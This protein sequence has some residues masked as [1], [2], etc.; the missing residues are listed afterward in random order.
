MQLVMLLLTS[1]NRCSALLLRTT[2]A[3]RP[4]S[5]LS[6]TGSTCSRILR[7]HLVVSQTVPRRHQSQTVP[8][9]RRCV[10]ITGRRKNT[11]LP[12][13]GYIDRSYLA[14]LSRININNAPAPADYLTLP[15]GDPRVKQLEAV[16]DRVVQAAGLEDFSW[17]VRLLVA[18]REC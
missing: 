11:S 7:P 10:P 9:S 1:Q 5:H 4:R 17:T 16:V 13:C 14:E 18:D 3:T 8:P 6:I 15:H 2:E 12:G